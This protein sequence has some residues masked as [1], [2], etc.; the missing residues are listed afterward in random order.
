MSQAL[1][2]EP[3]E[4]NPMYVIRE[5]MFRLGEDSDIINESREL[6]LRATARS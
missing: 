6:M 4:G 5:K 1:R 3:K 2:Q